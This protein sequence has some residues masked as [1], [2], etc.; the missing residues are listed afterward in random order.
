MVQFSTG[1]NSLINSGIN[2]VTNLQTDIENITAELF[3]LD[4]IEK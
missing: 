2:K 1:E 4:E 3:A